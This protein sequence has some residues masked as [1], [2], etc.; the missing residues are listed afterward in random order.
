M[1]GGILILFGLILCIV[2][3]LGS[4]YPILPGLPASWLG[5]LLFYLIPGIQ[6]NH[7]FL[8]ITLGITI[9]FVVLSYTV[10]ASGTKK[11]GGSRAGAIG[12][13]IGVIAGI[14]FMPL[15][16]LIGPF[17]GAFIGELFFNR[18]NINTSF[19]AA[20]G[21]FIGF[22]AGVFMNVIVSIVFL[23]M[24]IVMVIKNFSFLLL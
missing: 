22:L 14:F 11:F 12:T 4:V 18:S 6:V 5:L 8:G 13:T 2:G 1:L 9:L 10:P 3:V 17:I 19:K 24:F 15:G 23:V 7:W 16:I 20:F 21:S